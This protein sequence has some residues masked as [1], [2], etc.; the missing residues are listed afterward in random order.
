ME[1]TVNQDQLIMVIVN[2]HSSPTITHN[3][4]IREITR[5]SWYFLLFVGPILG[6]LN[7]VNLEIF[8]FHI[9]L[10]FPHREN[11]RHSAWIHR[12]SLLGLE[13]CVHFLSW[14]TKYRDCS[15]QSITLKKY[16]FHCQVEFPTYAVIDCS[17]SLWG[18]QRRQWPVIQLICSLLR[19]SN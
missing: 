7:G 11:L 14:L 3:V 18:L 2:T 13:C 19:D 8:C 1:E 6:V 17:Y 12:F 4:F 9:F 15:S 16:T 10:Y 5:Y